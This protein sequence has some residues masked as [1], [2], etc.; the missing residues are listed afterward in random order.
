MTDKQEIQRDITLTAFPE[1]GE[2]YEKQITLP[3]SA[4]KLSRAV[5]KLPV[6]V[7]APETGGKAF[8]EIMY[9]AAK[10]TVCAEGEVLADKNGIFAPLR[11]DITPLADGKT[12]ELEI[13]LTP[14]PGEEI[15]FG[16]VC[17]FVT[18]DSYFETSLRGDCGITVSAAVSENGSSPLSDAA[19]NIILTAHIVNPNNY[20]VLRCTL[21]SPDGTEKVKTCKPTSPTCIFTPEEVLF[22][23]GQHQSPLYTI[24]AEIVRDCKILDSAEAVFGVRKIAFDDG[25]L[26]LNSVKLPLNGIV[27]DGNARTA[28]DTELFNLLDANCVKIAVCPGI[29]AFLTECDKDG[30][31]AWVDFTRIFALDDTQMGAVAQSL[32]HHPSFVFAGL[33]S[34][35]KDSLEDFCT[36]IKTAAGGVF[37]AGAASFPEEEC[38]ADAVPDVVA[39]TVAANTPPDKFSE[40]G[41]RF[42]GFIANR[43]MR[44]TAVFAEPPEGFFERHSDHASRADCSQEFFA[45]WHEKFWQHFAAKKG[46][47]GCFAGA[48]ADSGSTSGRNGLVSFDRQDTKDAFWFYKAHFSAEGF[49][50]LCSAQ[51]TM[52]DKK[53]IDIRCYTNAPGAVLTVNGKKYPSASCEEAADCVYVFRNVKL[54]RKNNTIVLTA[55]GATDSA[56]IYRSKSKLK[57]V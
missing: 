34:G 19:V 36:A 43:R 12:H 4:E 56:V 20:D 31:I 40:L 5:I 15:Y 21:I 35:E 29:D 10:T 41:N 27:T 11:L 33:D 2:K 39:V 16:K 52:T 46:V 17:S 23:N 49:V 14:L 48:L 53:S 32:A 26:T 42:D 28:D 7:E 9:S 57:K 24:R 45:M 1:K 3:F 13:E 22:W 8:I 54:K 30:V 6:C 25:F 51:S 38:V 18:A 55:A 50:K 37:T 47:F 44:H